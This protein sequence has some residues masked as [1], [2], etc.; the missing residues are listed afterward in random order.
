MFDHRSPVRDRPGVGGRGR[1]SDLRSR[2][3]PVSQAPRFEE[4]KVKG[5]KIVSLKKEKKEEEKEEEKT[6]EEEK[7]EG[8]K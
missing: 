7:T 6:S 5:P 4:I 2:L 8:N 1:N 3:K